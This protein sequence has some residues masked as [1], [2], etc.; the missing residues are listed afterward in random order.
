MRTDP[1]PPF[2]HLAQQGIKRLARFF[3]ILQRIDPHKDAVGLQQ[4]RAN[5]VGKLL[6][7]DGWLGMN[8]DRGELFED[9]MKAIIGRGRIASRLVVA[10]PDNRNLGRRYGYFPPSGKGRIVRLSK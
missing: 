4:L 10:P 9:A 3:A 7:I 6:V 2:G 8:A 5:F 1:W